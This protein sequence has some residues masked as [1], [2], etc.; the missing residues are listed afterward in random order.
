MVSIS[1]S[2]NILKL[3][4]KSWK[5]WHFFKF[6]S[7]NLEFILNLARQSRPPRIITFYAKQYTFYQRQWNRFVKERKREREKERKREREKKRER[8]KERKRETKQHTHFVVNSETD[9]LCLHFEFWISYLLILCIV[10]AN[11]AFVNLC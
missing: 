5:S 4:P 8:K 6:I 7:R 1:I 3:S 2:L 9:L 10:V 11:K